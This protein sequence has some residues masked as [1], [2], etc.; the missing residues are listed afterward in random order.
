MED[1]L[2][3]FLEHIDEKYGHAYFYDFEDG[4]IERAFKFWKY[5]ND[6]SEDRVSSHT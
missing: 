2:M 6:D 1:E 3:E 4:D 5:C